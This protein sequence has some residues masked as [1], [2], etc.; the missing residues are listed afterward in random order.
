MEVTLEQDMSFRFG[1]INLKDI[2]QN[3]YSE[4]RQSGILSMALTLTHY[5]IWDKSSN[6]FMPQFPHL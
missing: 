6:Y 1:P 2:V 5:R 4:S 3:I